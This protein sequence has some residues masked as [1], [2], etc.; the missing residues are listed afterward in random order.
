[1]AA[2]V[3]MAR[4]PIRERGMVTQPDLVVVADETLLGDPAAQVLAGCDGNSVLL[5]NSTKTEADLR[6]LGG[7]GIQHICCADFTTAV[8]EHTRALSGLSTALAV[9]A[10][11]LVGLVATDIE[12]GMREELEEHVSPEHW[13]QNLTLAK[14]TYALTQSWAPL[15][16]R[17]GVVA[18]ASSPTVEVPFAPPRTA[19]PAVYAP[20]NTPERRTGNWRQFR[21]TLH[22]ELCTRCWICFV[23]CPEAAI[24]LDAQDYPVV[25]YDECKGCL[26]CVHEC[27]TH[28]FMA[29]KEAR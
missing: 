22:Q 2:L 28:A 27:P 3:R 15:R 26:L 5:I 14:A 13:Q 9:A 4:L 12:A 18:G 16:E 8:L 25:D 10:A 29:E 1:M 17:D 7:A 23:R 6:Q 11:R 20:A 21:P 19:T 24:S